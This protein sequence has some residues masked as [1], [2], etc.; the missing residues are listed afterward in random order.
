MQSHTPATRGGPARVTIT[1]MRAFALVLALAATC[2]A[3]DQ[4]VAP[5]AP[6]PVTPPRAD[7][8]PIDAFL[9]APKPAVSDAMFTRRAYLDIWG[10]LPTPE[11]LKDFIA[12]KSPSKRE[13]LIDTLLAHK[14]NYSGHWITFWNDLLRND[15]GVI[16]HGDRKSITAWL[17][18]ALE[19]NLPYNQFVSKLLNPADPGDPDGFVTGVTWR[20]VVN[21]SELPPMQAAQNSAQIFL[22]IN[23]KCNSCHD[24]FISR[25]KLADAYGLASFFS[26]GPLELVRCDVKQGKTAETKFLFPELG[27]VPQGAS[28]A[29]RRATAARLFTAPENGRFTRTYVNRIWALLTGKGLVPNVDDMASRPTNA[30]LLD[31]LASDFAANHYDSKQLLRTIMTSRAYQAAD[32]EPRRLSAEQFLDSIAELTCEWRTLENRS[33][34]SGAYTREWRFKSTPLSRA[35]GR[36]IRDQVT[37]VRLT[38]PT[39]LQALELVNGSTLAALLHRASMRMLGQLPPAPQPLFDS[40]SVRGAKARPTVDLDL[41]GADELYLL[42]LDVDSYDPAQVRGGFVDSGLPQAESL[43]L[44][45]PI[46]IDVRNQNRKRFTATAALDPASTTSDINGA[47]RFFVFSSAPDLTRLVPASGPRPVETAAYTEQGLI[48]RLYTFAFSRPPSPNE[49]AIARELLGAKPT[50]DSLEDLLWTLV[51]SPE[52]GYIR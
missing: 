44:N 24:S 33:T 48:D 26:E 47:V 34:K 5:L 51:I 23:L 9:G 25:W 17:K 39:T 1:H 20:G 28:L 38:Q 31:W 35:L 6:R 43:P 22:G 52:F 49:T 8:H 42:M 37:T 30:D 40:G 15:E 45:T 12:D 3:A 2:A 14:E 7:L 50:V 29:D 19:E 46:R 36:P 4:W 41:S 18:R 10:L 11:Q 13:R 32:A 16:Y 27:P 21:S